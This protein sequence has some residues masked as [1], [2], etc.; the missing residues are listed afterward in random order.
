MKSSLR[1]V[2]AAWVTSTGRRTRGDRWSLGVILHELAT[3]ARPF[4]GATTAVV[5]DRILNQSVPTLPGSGAYVPAGL[6]PIV[7]RLLEKD[8]GRDRR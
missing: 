6:S 1:S 5:F 8:P 3:G 4:G 2:R 7:A